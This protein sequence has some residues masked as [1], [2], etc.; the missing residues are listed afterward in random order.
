VK[1]TPGEWVA[2]C[3]GDTGGENPMPVYEV[4]TEDG[5]ARVCEHLTE[6]DAKLIAAAPELFD[7]LRNLAA[8]YDTDD[9]CKSAPEYVA[10]RT[11]IRK[12]T[13]ENE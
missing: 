10:A 7:A 6:A 1:L 4:C 9:G 13:G 2:E 8:L 3:V 11:A 12:A 5:Y